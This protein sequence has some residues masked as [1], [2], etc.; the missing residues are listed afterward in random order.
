MLSCHHTNSAKVEPSYVLV[1]SW[2]ACSC[3]RTIMVMIRWV[4][5]QQGFKHGHRSKF[6]WLAENILGKLNIMMGK[7]PIKVQ[8]KRKHTYKRNGQI[9]KHTKL[10]HLL[11]S[12]KYLKCSQLTSS[13]TIIG[14]RCNRSSIVMDTK[15]TS[16]LWQ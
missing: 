1:L 3:G 9:C 5:I 4:V 7:Q 14:I 6:H 12:T 16:K 13:R 11:L 15:L 2:S 8:K 10:L